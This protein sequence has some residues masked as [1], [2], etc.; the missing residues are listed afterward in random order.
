MPAGKERRMNRIF[1]GD[2]WTAICPMD[3][4][5]SNG[6]IDGIVNIDRTVA[7]LHIPETKLYTAEIDT[8][9]LTSICKKIETIHNIAMSGRY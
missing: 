2:E 1:R 4:G 5:A 9:S 7:N 3:D 6:L 8:K